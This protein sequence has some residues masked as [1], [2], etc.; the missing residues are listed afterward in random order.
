[1][2]SSA[3]PVRCRSEGRVRKYEPKFP[4]TPKASGNLG[5]HFSAF[6]GP[7]ATATIPFFHLVLT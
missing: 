6:F 4:L 7:S 2:K 3:G 5:S 1:M